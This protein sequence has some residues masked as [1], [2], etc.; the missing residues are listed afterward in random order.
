MMS[1][2]GNHSTLYIV[3]S[4]IPSGIYFYRLQAGDF[5]QTKSMVL[6]K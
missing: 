2:A 6:I 5:T 3:N 4:S 1:D